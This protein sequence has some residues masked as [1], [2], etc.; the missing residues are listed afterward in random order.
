LEKNLEIEMRLRGEKV[1]I[2]PM[3]REDVDKIAAWRP[4]TDPLYSLWS[5]QSRS[6]DNYIR[7]QAQADDPSRQWYAI[8]DLAGCLIGRLSLRQISRRKSARLGITL[9]ADYVDQ[10][11]GTDAIR[12]FLIYYF[13]DMGFKKLY[14]DVAAPNRRAI[15]CYEKCGFQR[16]GS[17]YQDAGSDQRLTFLDDKRYRD[18]RRFFKKKRGHNVV[19]FYDMKI[20]KEDLRGQDERK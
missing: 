4:S 17:H 19:L 5:S 16:T 10:G 1:I 18:I 11:Y 15:R 13:R 6:N 8:E 14:L 12:T 7:F 9:G 3:V 20:Q 2:R